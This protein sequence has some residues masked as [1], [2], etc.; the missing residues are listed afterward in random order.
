M[1]KNTSGIYP[2]EYKV[3]VKPDVAAK[4]TESG[5]WIP[6]ETVDRNQAAA[7]KGEI[8]DISPLAFTYD[9]WPSDERIPKV[10]DMVAFARYA[11][12]SIEGDDGEDYRLVSDKEV[13]ATLA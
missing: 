5:I 10:G 12:V 8:I 2:T 3:L 4:K 9:D 11:G 7:T 13:I 6:D 1:T